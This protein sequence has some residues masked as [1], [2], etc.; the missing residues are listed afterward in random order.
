MNFNVIANKF[1]IFKKN[2]LVENNNIDFKKINLCCGSQKIP[3]YLG[4]DILPD[5]DIYLDLNNN[6]LP[7]VDNSV[8]SLICMSA[9]NYFSYKRAEE[10][11]K[12][13]Y[14]I[15]CS[16]GITR[17]GVQDLELISK[18]YVEKN[19]DFFFQKLS[20]GNERFE[21]ETLGDKYVAWFYGYN[22]SGNCCKYF[23]DYDSLY[24]IFKKA[25]FSIIEKKEYMNSRLENIDYIDNRPEQMFYL[26]AIK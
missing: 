1:K 21:G 11:I 14:R 10:I 18:L 19:F 8:E 7:I 6:N 17:F 4:I 5:S 20:N 2:N 25:G 12:E 15:L 3:G 22:A 9:I 24:N 16:G 23:F 13:V 26:E